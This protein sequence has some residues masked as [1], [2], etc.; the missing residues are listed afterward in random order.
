MQFFSSQMLPGQGYASK[1]VLGSRVDPPLHATM[2]GRTLLE[3]SFG[4]PRNILRSFTQRGD[5]QV[6]HIDAVVEIRPE[7]PGVDH[8]LQIPVSRAYDPEVHRDRRFAAYANDLTLVQNAQELPLH[9]RR[10]VPDFVEKQRSAVCEFEH[11][12]LTR[13]APVN[14][15]FS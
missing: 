3:E 2:L 8:A 5:V 7:F 12:L 15:P 11:A 14:A 13:T 9:R 1:D 6:N 10:H 4:K